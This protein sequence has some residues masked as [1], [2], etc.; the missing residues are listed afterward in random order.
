MFIER[1]TYKRL[2]LAPEERNVRR[3]RVPLP[4]T[5][6]SAGAQVLGFTVG[7]IDIRLLRSQRLLRPWLR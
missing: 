3:C 7:S 5:S 6:R 4:E 2:I 1:A